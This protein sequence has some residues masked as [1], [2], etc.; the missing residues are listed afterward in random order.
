VS[1]ALDDT[2]V[3]LEGRGSYAEVKGY[4]HN[5]CVEREIRS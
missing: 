4:A 3:G 5:E 1:D 2:R